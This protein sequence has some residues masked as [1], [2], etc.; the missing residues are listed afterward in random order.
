MRGKNRRA[1]CN[2][3]KN[4]FSPLFFGDFDLPPPGVECG[5]KKRNTKKVKTGA[6]DEKRKKRIRN[7]ASFFARHAYH[8]R[9]LGQTQKRACDWAPAKRGGCPLT[10]ATGTPR[11]SS[12]KKEREKKMSAANTQC[13]TQQ[14]STQGK[15]ISCV[16]NRRR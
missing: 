6:Q 3:V 13:G 14:D 12:F 8:F 7:A 15:L 4:C 11:K 1:S 9:H 10:G 5:E 2:S 16:T